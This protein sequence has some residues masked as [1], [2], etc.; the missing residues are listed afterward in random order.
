MK[1]DR[2]NTYEQLG[3]KRIDGSELDK[4]EVNPFKMIGK[5]WMLITAGN[6]EGHNMMT[7]SW[8]F[9]GVMWG[10]NVVT[11]VVRPQRYTRE[12]IEKSEYFTLSFF[13]G[14]EREAL[15]FCGK[16]SGRDK[17]K[18]AETG[19]TPM[20]LDGTTSFEQAKTVVVCKKL[21]SQEMNPEGFVDQ[22]FDNQWYPG[23]DYHIAYVGEIVAVYSK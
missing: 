16:Y 6:E 8:G 5:D 10:K 23:K 19:L 7:A 22:S 14:A 9:M 17:N 11:A 15:A 20:Y 2:T 18:T 21:Y 13:D 12:F 4:I 1:M 3:F